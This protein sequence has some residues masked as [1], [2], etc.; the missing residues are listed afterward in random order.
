MFGLC[1]DLLKAAAGT[2][3]MFTSREHLPTPFH[4]RRQGIE[5]GA[6]SRKDAIALVGQVMTQ[7]S[8]EPQAED[9]GS[10]DQEVIDLVEAVNC[11]ARALA[12]DPEL[13]YS[14]AAE[15]QLLLEGLGGT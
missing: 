4:H 2:R 14:D 12:Q 3:L 7:E 5:L 9:P 15:L 1:Q 10:T 8:L 6:L 13:H 11:H